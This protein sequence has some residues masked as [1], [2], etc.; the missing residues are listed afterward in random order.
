MS[1][2][3]TVT[4]VE[5]KREYWVPAYGVSVEATSAEEAAELAKQQIEP[6]E[7]GDA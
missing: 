3:Q 5:V 1:G 7:E 2:K 4:S 6:R